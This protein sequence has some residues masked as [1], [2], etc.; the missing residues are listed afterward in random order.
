MRILCK[1]C[2]TAKKSAIS[3]F[4]QCYTKIKFDKRACICRKELI[5]WPSPSIQTSNKWKF[6]ECSCTISTKRMNRQRKVFPRR[7]CLNAKS[8]V[9]CNDLT[10]RK[11]RAFLLRYWSL[12]KDQLRDLVQMNDDAALPCH[13]DLLSAVHHYGTI[14]RHYGTYAKRV[15]DCLPHRLS[16]LH[17]HCT[18]QMHWLPRRG[19][20]AVLSL[21]PESGKVP[22]QPQACVDGTALA[23]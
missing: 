20:H 18:P 8:R 5:N 16:R 11:Q 10:T 6:M 17:V 15:C 22:L 7:L 12:P 1:V 23:A 13:D 9:P 21:G 19:A 14:V 4:T 3:D 2:I